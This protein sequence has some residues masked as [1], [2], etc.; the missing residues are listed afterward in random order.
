M[1]KSISVLAG[2]FLLVGGFGVNASAA[3]ITC[4]VS[5]VNAKAVILDCGEKS[6]TLKV[7]D[8]VTLKTRSPKKK[9]IEGC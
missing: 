5:A 4:T 3:R 6:L 2:L 9:V 7:G 1:K 8:K